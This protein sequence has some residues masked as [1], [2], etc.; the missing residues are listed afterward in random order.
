MFKNTL[1]LHSVTTSAAMVSVFRS[2]KK[3]GFINNQN[4]E[5]SVGVSA[6]TCRLGYQAIM[7]SDEYFY[8]C[9]VRVKMF[10]FNFK[11]TDI[12]NIQNPPGGLNV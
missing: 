12:Q 8:K 11:H 10:E 6:I 5:K 1:V 7:N 3:F 2:G 4:I 9:G